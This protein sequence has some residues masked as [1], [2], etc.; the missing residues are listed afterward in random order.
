V[1][2]DE[3]LGAAE[4]DILRSV[5]AVKGIEMD[6]FWRTLEPERGAYDFSLI[7]QHLAALRPLNKRLI[8]RVLDRSFSSAPSLAVLLPPYLANEPGGLGGWFD[9]GSAGVVARVWLAPIADRKIALLK[10][11]AKRY[12]LDPNVEA[13]LAN[14]ESS[15]GAGVK[16]G[17]PADYT[18]AAQAIQIKRIAEAA[19]AAWPHTVVISRLNH[20]GDDQMPG[21]V[22]N[23]YAN[24][25][26]WGGPDVAP[27]PHNDT[28]ASRIIQAIEPGFTTNYCGSVPSSFV[29]A[30]TPYT[31]GKDGAFTAQQFYDHA[32]SKLHVT[33][34]SWVRRESGT[35]PWTTG[36][37]PVI[38]ANPTINSGCPTQYRNRC[39]TTN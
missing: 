17:I 16:P 36:I 15:P 21:L 8:I 1:S 23:H 9:K 20:L 32:R 26:G 29:A 5:P 2:N 14:N 13:V 22:Q 39:D 31:G 33:H 4:L 19:V 18:K 7:D 30:S 6:Y 27:A 34:L 28:L 11:L 37:L 38:L 12:D 24:A 10:A 25:V 35:A 3:V